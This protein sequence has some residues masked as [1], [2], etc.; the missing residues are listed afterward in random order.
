M[1]GNAEKFDIVIAG[2]GIVGACLACLLDGLDLRIALAERRLPADG[3][4]PF[5]APGL[6]FDPRVS[7]LNE[8]SRRTLDE[9]GAWPEIRAIRCCDY[10]E[11]RVWDADGTGSLHFSAAAL[12]TES[13]G[14]IVENSVVLARLYERLR[15]QEN[16]RIVAPFASAAL[17]A[18]ADGELVLAGEPGGRL[19]TSLLV[20]A[21]GGDSAIRR[22]ANM[23]SR[24]WDYGQ[25][26]L[27]TTVRTARPHERTAW[28][29]FLDSGPLALLPLAAAGESEF[30]H[31]SIV[32]STRPEAAEQLAQLPEER[33]RA[34][35]ATAAEHRLGEIEWSDRRFCFPLRRHHATNYVKGNVVLVGDAAHTI[36]PLAGQGVNLGIRDAAA[37]AQELRAGLAAGRS[38][39]DPVVLARYERRRKGDNLAMMWAMEG[40]HRLFGARPPPWRWLRNTGLNLVDRTVPL[41]NFLARRAI[42]A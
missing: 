35:L 11:M 4:L 28:Q 3:D 25:A 27:V 41:K 13:L 16:L 21:D 20:G 8:S 39:R 30:R 18:G 6:R 12:E 15:R 2:G 37:L 14:T 17:D 9:I 24:E 5:R 42:G 22:L 33:F 34:R 31:S 26:A 36:H 40:L 29:V 10:R 1:D 23:P 19:R 32:W 38:L 7:A